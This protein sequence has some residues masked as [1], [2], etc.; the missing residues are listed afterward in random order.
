MKY[1]FSGGAVAD[2]IL[3][4]R[5]RGSKLPVHLMFATKKKNKNLPSKQRS[6][7]KNLPKTNRSSLLSPAVNVI[8][9]KAT[10]ACDG[11]CP[12]CRNHYLSTGKI[13][14]F[15]Q[16]SVNEKDAS[17][18]EPR[19]ADQL[20]S[21]LIRSNGRQ[22]DRDVRTQMEPAFNE[23]F[24][25]VRVHT[26]KSADYLSNQLHAKAFTVGKNIFFRDGHYH[27]NGSR[28]RELLAHE[29]T[30]VVQQKGGR[31]HRKFTL[32]KTGDVWEKE[33]NR[34]AYHVMRHKKSINVQQA[35]R[36][37]S[38]GNNIPTYTQEHYPR[39]SNNPVANGLPVPK[40]SSI[41]RTGLRIMR[42]PVEDFIRQRTT[43]FVLR[44]SLLGRDLRQ[45][46]ISHGYTDESIRFVI[47]VFDALNSDQQ[48]EVSLYFLQGSDSQ[49][50]RT[51][52]SNRYGRTL[53]IG[54]RVYLRRGSGIAWRL[55]GE[56]SA[57]QSLANLVSRNIE[58]AEERASREEAQ[59]EE[60]VAEILEGMETSL[61]TPVEIPPVRGGEARTA[62]PEG[63]RIR[64]IPT[65]EYGFHAQIRPDRSVLS[66][67]TRQIILVVNRQQVR[68]EQPF[69]Y[70]FLPPMRVRNY[71]IIR[72]VILPGVSVHQSGFPRASILD[73]A[74]P[75]LEIYRVHDPAQVPRQG[76]PI[77]PSRYVGIEEVGELGEGGLLTPQVTTI[78]RRPD[79]VDI[80]HVPTRVGV[81]VTVPPRSGTGCFA[82]EV[83]PPDSM[84]E[85]HAT[86][87]TVV[88]TPA[89]T[90]RL[91]NLRLGEY[92]A[93]PLITLYEAPRLA[94][95]PAQGESL[96]P[97][98]ESW[99]HW[100]GRSVEV[101]PESLSHLVQTTSLDVAIGLIPIVGDLADVAEFTYGLFTGQDRWGRPL[102]A[103][104]LAL[105]GIGVLIPFV[106]ASVL[107]T[108]ATAARYT[109]EVI[110]F[111]ESIGRNPDEVSDM[112]RRVG[113][114]SSADQQQITRWREMIQRGDAIPENELP[115]VQR[116][117]NR[118]DEAVPSRRTGGESGGH[119][120]TESTGTTGLERGGEAEL[121]PS[122][123]QAGDTLEEPTGGSRRLGT[124]GAHR[125]GVP[126]R[127]ARAPGVIETGD[128]NALSRIDPRELYDVL[129]EHFDDINWGPWRRFQGRTTVYEKN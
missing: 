57:Y 102:T 61:I 39:D 88:A 31:S 33:A 97:A 107:R 108:G 45:H 47:S 7:S 17:I 112:L 58:W 106:G 92:Y 104:D 54:L 78:R 93:D 89:T 22:L 122:L 56:P 76:E 83:L 21:Q 120:R 121:L 119:M 68:I 14:A 75:A 69:A 40:G 8:Q 72:L 59:P 99:R 127:V 100:P 26:D 117:L 24:S 110:E 129:T 128:P 44:P 16:R 114:L 9:R 66:Y 42:T 124:S 116:I 29:L 65:T 103:T 86:H 13:A 10:C 64:I 20:E 70:Q 82:Y 23:D 91:H 98:R 63:E 27:P 126:S 81:S 52:V 32:G 6:K 5:Y 115:E 96:S 95:V 105:I 18:L 3:D 53:F 50:R 1:P 25:D 35:N 71:P 60:S 62:E 113:R 67:G 37:D 30:H 55:W 28:G 12:K 15:V 46:I 11:D 43:A 38:K 73:P 111:A 84:A 51:L 87:I 4:S 94:D 19:I 34:F 74:N 101:G 36:K 79:G 48:S 118:V 49:F 90:I 41:M 80:T 125:R 77:Q 2:G 123:R 109:D 85:R